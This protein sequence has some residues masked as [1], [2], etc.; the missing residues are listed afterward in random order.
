MQDAGSK[1]QDP[2]GI[3]SPSRLSGDSGAE[4]TSALDRTIENSPK[5]QNEGEGEGDKVL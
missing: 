1:I 4:A 5:G 3:P 2:C